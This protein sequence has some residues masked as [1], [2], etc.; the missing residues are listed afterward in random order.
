[1]KEFRLTKKHIQNG[2]TA[3]DFS[4]YAGYPVSVFSHAD[5]PHWDKLKQVGGEPLS[6]Q[7]VEERAAAMLAAMQRSNAT[8]EAVTLENVYECNIG[9]TSSPTVVY[10]NVET[11]DK[12]FDP[13]IA[14]LYAHCAK[15]IA[16]A[17]YA[18]TAWHFA[19]LASG[20]VENTYRAV[21]GGK[22]L[23]TY[24]FAIDETVH[25]HRLGLKENG[26]LFFTPRD[27]PV[28]EQ[29][30][31]STALTTDRIKNYPKGSD[32]YTHAET[33]E[34]RHMRQVHIGTCTPS[35]PGY[36][37][38][39]DSDFYADHKH[40]EAGL[41]HETR[42]AR[43]HARHLSV[44]TSSS[45]YWIAPALDALDAGN[46]PPDFPSIACAA[47]EIRYR[48]ISE[49]QDGRHSAVSSDELQGRMR[50]G[51]PFDAMRFGMEDQS[52]CAWEDRIKRP[53]IVYSLLGELL[54]DNTFTEPLA[55]KM[56][57]KIVKAAEYF[58]PDLTHESNP[59]AK[60]NPPPP[61]PI[62]ASMGGMIFM[63]G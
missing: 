34:L 11:K 56:A 25:L 20:R 62:M 50:S 12:T 42:I 57:N 10:F 18:S 30:A 19:A 47:K 5:F 26:F 54:E 58:N 59:H 7:E 39:L 23:V 43:R 46:M 33:H 48:L 3:A 15:E 27:E 14:S 52:F 49:A 21:P 35:I 16:G 60:A 31:R 17:D 61:M 8:A 63:I 44:I 4:A 1:M 51:N 32:A 28:L 53:E 36:Y 38:E 24:P 29:W 37:K 22:R 6:E 9:S 41:P 13:A 45:D 2:L 55:R 40:A